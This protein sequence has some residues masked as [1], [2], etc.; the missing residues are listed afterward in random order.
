MNE[1]NERNIQENSGVLI[2]GDSSIKDEDDSTRGNT[3]MNDSSYLNIDEETNKDEEICEKEETNKDEEISGGSCNTT[4]D[5]MP[6][7]NTN[8]AINE[9][10]K[11]INQQA[12]LY[13]IIIG[14][15]FSIIVGLFLTIVDL[16][17]VGGSILSEPL[18][19]GINKD[20]ISMSMF[21]FGTIIAQLAFSLSSGLKS[22]IMAGVIIEAFPIINRIQINCT[23]EANGD[24]NIIITNT[25][26]CISIS[27][28]I[29]SLISFL[30]SKYRLEV[31]IHSIPKAVIYGFLLTIGINLIEIGDEQVS[32]TGQ[33]LSRVILL[34]L[35]ISMF[36]I[37]ELAPSFSLLTPTFTTALIC[38][39][40]IIFKVIL[41]KE[42]TE[43]INDGW[44]GEQIHGVLSLKEVYAHFS[45]RSINPRLIMLCI[46]DI[47]S[48]AITS[49]IHLP[50][51]LSSFGQS[52]NVSFKF[53]K[54]LQAQA[55]GNFFSTFAFIPSY[56][57][58][59]YSV[60]FNR[61]GAK[62]KYHSIALALFMPILFFYGL[63]I[64]NLTPK[65]VLALI[66]CYIGTDFCISSLFG[67]RKKMT[68]IEYCIMFI[69]GIIG[70]YVNMF[71]A[72]F[73]GFILSSI[74]FVFY[75]I[76]EINYKHVTKQQIENKREMYLDSWGNKIYRINIEYILF[77]TTAPRIRLPICVD[78]MII[79][80][81]LGLCYA[82]DCTGNIK[83]SEFLDELI[84]RKCNVIIVGRPLNAWVLDEYKNNLNVSVVEKYEEVHMAM[85]HIQSI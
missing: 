36:I 80:I 78:G 82:M 4:S 12:S 51:N 54:E 84:K 16:V 30:I 35:V 55:I 5:V 21:V 85:M 26:L 79:V 52:V 37:Q 7:S 77:F 69:T 3:T 6:I 40:Y 20:T 17:S 74:L 43:L 8:S 76:Q 58:N 75:Y 39:F 70:I 22:G 13:S 67:S 9:E 42:N 45:Y 60:I 63:T 31:I 34:L 19:G 59:S 66:P 29:F 56:F 62:T 47:L 28:I 33:F 57:I 73:I 61:V 25:L 32:G 83:F 27:V 46:S 23:K 72:L 24:P 15:V 2:K 48:L 14:S 49:L 64:K 65:I 41:G 18:P 1:D 68:N 50:I 81:D 53:S 38:L 11:N 10:N 71:C 44:L